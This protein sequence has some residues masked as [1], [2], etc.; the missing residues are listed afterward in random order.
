MIIHGDLARIKVP[1]VRVAGIA[2]RWVVAPVFRCDWCGLQP[3]PR[4]V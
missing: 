3:R 4:G 2:G 1:V